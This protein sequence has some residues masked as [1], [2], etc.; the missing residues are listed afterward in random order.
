VGEGA[1][2]GPLCKTV[3]GE[4]AED[5]RCQD[6]VGGADKEGGVRG[7][8]SGGEGNKG[9]R[10]GKEVREGE[11]NNREGEVDCCCEK[12]I[13]YEGV[14]LGYKRLRVLKPWERVCE[15]V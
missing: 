7:E 14:H 11:E 6:T 12:R 4:G 15:Y 2:S 8:A 13:V 3:E 1:S 10:V 9:W 5:Y